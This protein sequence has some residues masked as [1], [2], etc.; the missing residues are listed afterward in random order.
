MYNDITPPQLKGIYYVYLHEHVF[1][2][3]VA[4]D[5]GKIF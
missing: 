3:Q 1:V 4:K 5:F 2:S